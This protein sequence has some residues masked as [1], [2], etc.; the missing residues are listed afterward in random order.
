MIL[1][2]AL[3]P[4][5]KRTENENVK[6]IVIFRIACTNIYIV[7]ARIIYWRWIRLKYFVRL[8]T[9]YGY[10]LW[11]VRTCDV[12]LRQSGHEVS[13]HR[14]HSCRDENRWNASSGVCDSTAT[15]STHL[16]HCATTFRRYFCSKSYGI[17]L[18]F[19]LENVDICLLIIHKRQ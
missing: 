2:C 11:L 17:I 1:E 8:S 6:K 19:P 16:L 12:L 15:A 9:V 13:A 14:L 10:E 18:H 7:I 5:H 3:I 4:Q